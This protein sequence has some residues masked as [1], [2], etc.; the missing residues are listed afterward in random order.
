MTFFGKRRE[1]ELQN[2]MAHHLHH[3]AAEYQRQ[4]YSRED[5]WRQ[6]RREFGGPTQVQER[7]RDERRWAWMTGLRQDILF[8]WRMMR[9]NPVITTAAVISLALGIG[10]NTAIVSLMDRVLWRD[11]PLPNP[12]Q[13][14]LVHWKTHAGFPKELVDSASGSMSSADGWDVADFF[15]YQGFAQMRRSLS[16]LASVAA[17]TYPDQVSVSFAG[18]PT[19]ARERA[20]SGN[21]FSTLE[22]RPQF[23]RLLLDSDDTYAAP[24][25][26][27]VSHGFW[28]R[29]LGADPAVAGRTITIN[30]QTYL[31]AGVLEPSFYGLATGDAAEIYTPM[32][33]ASFLRNRYLE[34]RSP[35]ENNRF[36]GVQLLARRAA[37]VAE[38]RLEPAMD[39]VFRATWA[40][41]PKDPA[42]APRVRL[43]EGRRGLGLVRDDFRDP[44]LVLGGL[45][46]LLLAIA[47]VNIANLLLARANARQ[48][49]L[50]LRISLG[51]GRAR[52][53]RQLL[54][55]SALLALMGGAASIGIAWVTA[56][57]LGR[58]LSGH[59]TVAIGFVLDGRM[60][61]MVGAIA[62][63]ALLVFGLFPAWQASRRLDASS[64]K[65]GAGSIGAVSRRGWHSGRWFV[66][67]QM[68][69]S[70]ILV[71][72]AVIFTRNL[73]GIQS[74]DP[75]FDRR[76]LILFG[77]RPGTSGYDKSRLA[78]FYFNLEQR[79]Q[80]TPGVSAAAL[81][82]VRPMNM[83]GWWE[84]V[85]LAGQANRY[86]VSVN[87]V[88][89]SY[90]PLYTS[91]MVAGRNFNRADFNGPPNVAII[92]E[93][94][95]RKMGGN[96][97][98]SRLAMTDGPPGA[99]RP[100]YEIVGIAPVIAV[101]SIK[102]RPNAL[103]LPF[104][105]DTPEATV[106]LRTS[107]PPQALLPAIRQA[108]TEVDRNLPMVDT[109][110]MEEQISMNLQ[111][112]RMFATLCSGFGILALVLSVVGLYGVI[113]YR[114][115]RRRGEIGV[116]L[117]LGAR[118]RNVVSL[119]LRE[120]L[121]MAVL[122]ILLGVP[123]L[124]LG[125]KYLQKELTNMK[126]L[127]P[128]SL[129]VTLGILLLSALF[130]AGIPARRASTMDPAE[131][132]RQE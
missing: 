11:L 72:T 103:W 69:L 109:I 28:V 43:D 41:P 20:V 17:F 84:T 102:E 79:L 47:C 67:L 76:N 19:V 42:V 56:T 36:W 117:A 22:A 4:G 57:L 34:A 5:A 27:V 74:S 51:C 14:T 58:F 116:R 12:Q 75:G 68:A 66:T 104:G 44:L 61:A 29:A 105:G 30:N 53:M 123:F 8:G 97:L 125:G 85:G 113:S 114:T 48:K 106:V 2:E 70:V 64:L 7:C 54:T 92:S 86:D 71:M 111:R 62:A 24:A 128:L 65:Q 130:A 100:E 45:V 94:L 3:L 78:Q 63:A 59:E 49:E 132:L 89:S 121:G 18:R 25:A 37:G 16:A 50:A 82:S 107:Q 88:T 81:A 73:T 33:H 26:A 118:P 87:G 108:V 96:V 39:A 32:H 46:T 124:W 23:G 90:L 120:G 129:I 52:L 127:D 99:K 31:I 60:I 6:A 40:Q 77:T 10:A 131:T 110:T 21:F 38:S 9:R 101:T 91:R 55:E 13:L 35:L 80:A 126:P 112:E 83:G 119:I 15:S 1:S 95:A 115:S 122:G 98:G 93:D